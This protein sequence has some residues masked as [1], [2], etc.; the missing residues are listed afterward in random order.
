[1]NEFNQLDEM[2][3]EIILDH[4]RSPRNNHP[5]DQPT[6]EI[7]SNNPFCGDEIKLQIKMEEG[8]IK[9][10][11]ITGRGC[12]ISQASASLM[13]E[14]LLGKEIEEASVIYHLFREL[15]TGELSED[16]IDQLGDSV[17]LEGVK[18]F[19]IRVKCAILSWSAMRDMLEE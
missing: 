4:Y 1:M 8:R 6:K 19:P 9:E 15:L 11:G 3:R 2:Y 5:V 16:K 14:T 17:A 10:I 13:G 12:A 18:K 7:E